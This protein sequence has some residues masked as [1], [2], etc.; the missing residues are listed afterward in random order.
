ML[1]D[2][3][4]GLGGPVSTI[5]PRRMT[6]TTRNICAGSDTDDG[7]DAEGHEMS[8]NRSRQIDR[9]M[10]EQLLGGAPGGRTGGHDALA[11]LLAAAA[12]PAADG[13]LPGEQAALAAFRVARPTPVHPGGDRCSRPQ[14]RSSPA[15][16][17]RAPPASPRPATHK[18]LSRHP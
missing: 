18:V 10:A 9:D 5:R 6:A 3:Q 14:W 13:E 1:R 4:E 15:G 2:A 7:A 17:R 8:T 11:G 16:R 12:A